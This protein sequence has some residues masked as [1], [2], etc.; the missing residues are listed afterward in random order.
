MSGM[1][2]SMVTRSGLRTRYFS[3][4]WSPDSASPTTSNPAWLRMSLIMVRMKMASSQTST[5]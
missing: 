5:V 2:M 3:T 1:T 4:A